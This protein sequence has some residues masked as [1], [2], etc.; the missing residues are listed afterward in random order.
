MEM[1]TYEEEK[2]S[3]ENLNPFNNLDI[4]CPYHQSCLI[5][6]CIKDVREHKLKFH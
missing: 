5:T 2:I 6:K 1:N 4:F 3:T